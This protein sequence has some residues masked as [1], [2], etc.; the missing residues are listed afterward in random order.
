MEGV[1]LVCAELE[2]EAVDVAIQEGTAVGAVTVHFSYREQSR[3]G[4]GHDGQVVTAVTGQT[5]AEEETADGG[6]RDTAAIAAKRAREVR[7][8]ECWRTVE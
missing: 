6:R 4:E 3:S 2:L 7:R 8:S 5:R 1:E